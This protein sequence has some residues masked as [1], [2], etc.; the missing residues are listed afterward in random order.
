MGGYEMARAAL[1]AKRRL[2][3]GDGDPHVLQAKI[4]T[5]RFYAEQIMPRAASLVPIIVHGSQSVMSLD[6]DQF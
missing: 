2:D 1:A 3:A 5:A 4:A 6:D